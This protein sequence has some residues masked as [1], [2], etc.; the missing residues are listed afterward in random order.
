LSS[1]FFLSASLAAAWCFGS[2]F[3]SDAATGFGALSG[4]RASLT[5]FGAGAGSVFLGA[6]DGS[7]V[8]GAAASSSVCAAALG[9][10]AGDVS[11]SA[12]AFALSFFLAFGSG[13]VSAITISG[14]SP[15]VV[16]LSPALAELFESAGLLVEGVADPE[17]LVALGSARE[18]GIIKTE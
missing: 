13:G 17:E 15:E 11:F 7:A 18:R 14:C 6:G 3:G 12:V 16:A 4:S 5:G 1:F 9:L 2:C 8:D 10:S